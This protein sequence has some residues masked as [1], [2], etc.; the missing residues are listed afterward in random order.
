MIQS[1]TIFGYL[2]SVFCG[3]DAAMQKS[4]S[5]SRTSPMNRLWLTLNSV[6]FYRVWGLQSG[7]HAEKLK[8]DILCSNVPR[9]VGEEPLCSIWSRW[10]CDASAR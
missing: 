5:I 8:F 9:P 1:A 7:R 3:S 2:F 4:R 6:P 10:L